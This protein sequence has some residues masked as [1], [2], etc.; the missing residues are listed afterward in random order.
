MSLPTATRAGAT[1]PRSPTWAGW[2]LLL[3]ATL[4]AA[5]HELTLTET[6]LVLKADGTYQVDMTCDLDALAAGAPSAADSAALAAELR[7]LPPAELERRRER[8]RRT[9]ERRVRILFDGEPARPW[10][11][12]PE[13]AT[14]LAEQAEAPTVLGLTA[15]LAGRVPEGARQVAFRASRAFPPVHLTILHQ[16]NLEGRREVLERGAVSAAFPLAGAAPPPRRGAV[17]A[18][19]LRL[20]FAHIV[21]AGPDHM[22]FVLGLFL[23]CARWRPL[24]W[25]VSAFTAAHTLTLAL[26][27]WGVM[28]LP[29]AVVE[30]LIALSIAYVAIEN[31]FVR[32]L[33]PWR[34]ALVFAFGLLHGL[35]FAGVLAEL[36]LPRG[37]TT[38]A[39]VGFNLG[40]ELGQLAVLATA[41]AAV[42]WLRERPWYRTRVVVPASLAIAAMG[43]TWAVQRVVS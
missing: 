32:E 6:L 43:L 24:L 25:Q 10:I 12:F 29:T 15:R 16:A 38:T 35:G 31:L 2:V 30:P 36:G 3:L 39:L 37:E 27:T 40:V 17:L 8:L 33:K 26:A 11:S 34:P 9:F 18:Q 22:L 19:Y 41:F 42:G 14:P 4:P 23:L 13:H 20:G 21:P 1:A 7:A 5:A 28:T